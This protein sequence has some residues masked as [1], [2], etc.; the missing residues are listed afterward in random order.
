MKEKGEGEEMFL[1][2]DREQVY[3][4]LVLLYKLQ[5]IELPDTRNPKLIISPDRT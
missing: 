5:Y 3:T 4:A 2:I 1:F